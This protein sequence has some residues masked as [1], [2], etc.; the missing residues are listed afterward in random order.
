MGKTEI[1][2]AGEATKEERE[3]KKKTEIK[4]AGEKRR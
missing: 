1:K 4:R 2:R 3:H